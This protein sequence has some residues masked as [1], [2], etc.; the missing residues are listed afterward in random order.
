ML[1][2][3]FKTSKSIDVLWR[4]GSKLIVYQSN[5]TVCMTFRVIM[6]KVNE[7]VMLNGL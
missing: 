6:M 2:I 5:I 4:F 1:L 3:Y 7:L